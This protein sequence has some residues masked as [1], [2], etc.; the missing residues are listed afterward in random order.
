MNLTME[1]RHAPYAAVHSQEVVRGVAR[2]LDVGWEMGTPTSVTKVG[3]NPRREA[4]AD[5]FQQFAKVWRDECA[6]LSSVREMVL[7]PTYQQIV[8]MGSSALPFIFAELE[9]KPDHWFWALRAITQEDPVPPEHRGNVAEMAQD[10][11]DWA[12]KKGIR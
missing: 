5:R 8:G 1:D 7:H 9:R 11:L 6:H 2:L 10:W 4:L 3:W 12:K